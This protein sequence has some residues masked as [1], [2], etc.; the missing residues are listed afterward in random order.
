MD[1]VSELQKREYRVTNSR[2]VVCNILENSGH[3]HFTA[4]ALHKLALEIDQN[5]DLATI[6]RTLELLEEIDI[7]EHSHLPHGSGIYFLK[8]LQSSA[9]I[10]CD[11]CGSI[12][13]LKNSTTKNILDLLKSDSQYKDIRNHFLYSGVCKNC[14]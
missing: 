2:K 1:F 12:F 5:I 6:Y 8:N 14:K 4:D 10:I 11:I 13:D 7:V 3:E 9:H